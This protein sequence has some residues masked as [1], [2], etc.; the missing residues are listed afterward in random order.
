VLTGSV[1]AIGLA[2]LYI[3]RW[4]SEYPVRIE[5]TAWIYVASVTIVVAVVI[6]SIS[7][8]AIRLMRTNP[9]EALKKE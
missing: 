7:F 5:N 6:A 3:E 9:A 2:Y 4:L 1:I 8:Q